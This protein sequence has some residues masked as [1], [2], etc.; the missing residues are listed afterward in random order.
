MPSASI[1]A[2]A[3][4]VTFAVCSPASAGPFVLTEVARTGSELRHLNAP[5]I[6]NNGAIAFDAFYTG[7][8]HQAVFV[9]S[10]GQ[11]REIVANGGQFKR[12]GNPII[13]AAGDIAL[14]ARLGSDASGVFLLHDGS[15]VPI[16]VVDPSCDGCGH[17][18]PDFTDTGLIAFSALIEDGVYGIFRSDGTTTTALY[19]N[20]TT[21]FEGF[22]NP[23]VNGGG[24]VA[25]GGLDFDPPISQALVA[26]DGGALRVL[27]GL[28]RGY[29][30]INDAGV[31]AVSSP[32]TIG[33]ID[34]SGYHD[35]PGLAGFRD[36][37][38]FVALNNALQIAFVA[39]GPDG[40]QGLFVA[41]GGAILPVISVGD[42]LDGSTV[43]FISF[44]R[45]LNDLGQVAFQVQ[46]ANETQLIERADPAATAVPEPSALLLAST[47]CSLLLVRLR[48][49]TTAATDS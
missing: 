30:D 41:T 35:L 20:L 42:A 49:R 25:F 11:T 15:V 10:G 40:R 31:I 12:F 37:E 8:D 34:S 6:S 27:P 19:T 45:G 18:G 43:A 5:S 1:A 29:P 2:A 26:G 47:G 9:A 28:V 33:V 22:T 13:N 3:V 39:K 17:S 21:P 36:F 24:T 32:D 23:S 46:L 38:T 16:S 7:P 4:A 48:K 44:Y 14:W